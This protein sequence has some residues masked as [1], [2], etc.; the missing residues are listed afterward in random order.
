[1][2]EGTKKRGRSKEAGCQSTRPT[3][4]ANPAATQVEQREAE[5]VK[6]RKR[7]GTGGGQKSPTL[8]HR[9]VNLNRSHNPPLHPNNHPR[10]HLTR[11]PSQARAAQIPLQTFNLPT[12]PPEALSSGLTSLI[13][14]SDIKL[15]EY[16]ALLEQPFSVPSLPPTITSLTL[17]LFSLGYPPGFL[18][19]IG[20]K[21]PGLRSLTLY[22]QLLAG[23]TT[24]SKDDA[25]TFF[26]FQTQLQELHLLDVFGPKGFYTE[27]AGRVSPGLKFLEVNFTYRHS[28]PQFLSSLPSKEIV[29]F[30]GRQG[31]RLVGLTA[32]IS[33]PDVTDDEDDR[34]GTEVGILPVERA[35]AEGL[36]GVL[37]EGG[38]GGEMVMLDVTMFEL[39]LEQLADVVGG[40]GR[41]KI[42][43]VTVAVEKG[44]GEVFEVLGREGRAKGVEVLEIVGVPGQEFAE[45][46]K[47]GESSGLSAD[48]LVGVVAAGCEALK[49]VKVS[50]L[51]TRSEMW[52]LEGEVWSLKG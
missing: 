20:K 28:D 1:M 50:L 38:V 4:P 45:S 22:S 43:G 25:I 40:C 14:T 9:N 47:R 21:I 27:L 3:R 36:V 51:R 8:T 44:W 11:P 46:V 12:F 13:L 49:S 7:P 6:Q 52:V 32:S 42:L 26:R 15:E 35:H 30:L 37:K 16:Q 48:V 39:S 10:K 19:E 29:E 17:E 5:R 33:A 31:G 34:E 41:V 2:E 18:T 24:Y 23:T